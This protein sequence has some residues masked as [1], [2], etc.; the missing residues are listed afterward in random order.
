MNNPS[1]FVTFGPQKIRNVAP[2]QSSPSPSNDATGQALNPQLSIMVND[3]NADAMNV[4][5]RTNAS[6]SW[7]NIGSNN[8]VYNGTYSQTPSNMNSSSTTYYWSVNVT[9]GTVWTNATYNFTTATQTLNWWNTNWNY[10]KLGNITNN[11]NGYQMKIIVGNTSEGNVTCE[12]HAQSDFDDIR[13]ISYSDNTTTLPHWR[14]NYTTDTQATFW[15]NNSQNN[16]KIWMYYGNNS[17]TSTSNGT[18]TFYF[19]DNFDDNSIN[20]SKWTT[21]QGTWSETGG[22]MSQTSTAGGDPEKC[23]AISAPQSAYYAMRA[24]VRPNSGTNGD[25]RTGLSIKTSTVNG[26]GYNYL[27]HDFNSK[28]TEQF[29]DDAVAWGTSYARTAWSFGTWYW[30]EI[31]HDGTNVKGRIWDVGASPGA[32]NSWA[33]SGRSGYL[34][35]NGG[36]FGGTVSFDDVFVRKIATIEPLWNGFDSEQT[37]I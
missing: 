9:D 37:Q 24:K 30:F 10:R 29:L 26:Q 6:G 35:L 20:A 22:V 3:T 16:T 17:A 27:F 33:R 12:G 36:S 32:F 1:N 4:T 23:I 21:Y 2:T 13:F 28:T 19:F 7:A 18:N 25:E 34:A 8:S 31:Y 11:E 5:F 15:I 14:E